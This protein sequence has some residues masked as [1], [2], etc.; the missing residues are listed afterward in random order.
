MLQRLCT[1]SFPRSAWVCTS[2]RSCVAV[3]LATLALG[4][5]R[6][7]TSRLATAP[8]PDVLPTAGYFEDVTAGSGID[9][10][11]RNG[12]EAGHASI[13]ESLGG[14]AAL[15]DFDGDGLLDV[16][17]TGGGDFSGTDR[18]QIIG[19]PC[20]LYKNLG[21]FRFA[22]VT[23]TAGLERLAGE[24]PWFYSHGCAV[25]DYDNDGWPDLLVTGFGRLALFHN[26]PDGKGG[27]RFVDVTSAAGLAD[28]RWS[29]SAAWGDLDGDGFPDLYV[30]HYVD[31]SWANNPPCKDYRDQTQPDVC[32]PKIFTALPHVLYRNNRNGTFTDISAAAGLRLPRNDAAYAQLAHLDADARVR[33]RRADRAK[34]FGKGLG[35]L[36]ADLDDDGRPDIYVANDTS[37]NFL[38]LNR[39]AGRFEEAAIERGVATDDNGTPTG[40]MGVDAADYNG[41][42]LLSLFVSNYQNEPHALYRNRGKGNFLFVS[43][44]TG[45]AAIG[46]DYVGFGTGFLD[47]DADGHEDLF[48]SNGHVVHRPAPPADVRQ[49]PV[50][51]RNNRRPNDQ[52]HQV[53]F[54]NVSAEAGPY[55][56][57][58]HRG[59]GA[60]FGDLD[61]DGR[62]DIVLNPMN[63]PATVL[64]NRHDSGN[65]W[66][67]IA[68]V[69]Q[70]Y[71][72]AVGA[73]L[74][75]LVDG[76]RLV[77]TIKGGGSYLSSSDRRVVFGCGANDKPGTLTVRWPSGKKQTWNG[78]TVDRYWRLT[79][80]QTQAAP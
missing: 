24:K 66:L 64:R 50:L 43:R 74:E 19:R 40:S 62:L 52:P 31:W 8:G 51:L 47:F 41:S 3:L 32:A 4:C 65:H 67:G 60:A 76:R 37:G 78:L 80:G 38:Y 58:A 73:R 22:D 29:T 15:L 21:G 11:Y 71:R 44:S 18:K 5:G 30:C 10:T 42:G 59:R 61:N 14:G 23:A 9:F 72:D 79:E 25:A 68:L 54:V 39:G 48:I 26:E 69:G 57:I 36:I 46:L 7:P 53:G 63:E 20:K 27:R 1:F 49:R 16:F 17:L 34:D 12:E 45:I 13:L 2:R 55:F 70:P 35:V 77:R 6:N 33:L 75:L 28:N 56:Q